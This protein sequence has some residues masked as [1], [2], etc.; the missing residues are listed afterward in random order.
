MHYIIEG[1]DPAPFRPL[2]ALG[3][4]ALVE[5]GIVRVVADAAPGY[6]C[7]ITLKEAQPGETLLLLN[8]ESRGGDT[9]YR[10]RHAIFVRELAQR[11]ASMIDRVPEVFEPRQLSLRGFDPAGMMVDAAIAQP[12]EADALLRGLFED[13]RIVEID[14]HNAIRGCFAARARK[15]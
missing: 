2:F 7:R 15:V 1:L 4:E 9:P 6:P 5:Q 12:G 11:A 3:D 13:P 14:V 8:H 10:A